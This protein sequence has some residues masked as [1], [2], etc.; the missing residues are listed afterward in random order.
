MKEYPLHFQYQSGTRTWFMGDTAWALFTDNREKRHDHTSATHHLDTRAAQ[1]FNV[2]HAMMISEAGWGNSGGPAFK[3]LQTEQINPAYWQEV[4]ARIAAAN[5]KGIT[6]G[7]V[8]A[9]G[10][11]G[12]NPN[13][14]REFPSQEARLCYARYATAR[15]SAFDVYFIVAGEWN[16][17][18]RHAAGLTEDQIRS[19]YREIGQTVRNSDPHGRLIGIHPMIMGTSREFAAEPWCGFGDYQQMYPRLHAEILSSRATGKPVVNSEYAYYLRDQ[20]ED[21]VVDKQNSYD[22]DT[23]RHATWDIAMSGGY[24]IT[25]WGNTYFGGYR[26]PGP[27]DVDAP[28]N[29]N[30]EAQVQHVKHLFENLDWWRLEPFDEGITAPVVRSQDRIAKQDSRPGNTVSPPEAVYWALAEEG[31]LYVGYVRGIS[32]SVSLSVKSGKSYRIRQFNPRTGQYRDLGA[33][34][35]DPIAF[36]PPDAQDWVFLAQAE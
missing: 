12:R 32:G 2:V 11:K 18:V 14:W 21:G 36:A 3:N 30:W 27:F 28:Q 24:F 23:I 35:G 20:D 7:L 13:D 5:Q 16:A 6:V 29:D 15:Y 34:Q 25:G 4:D 10:D 26:N 22:L 8:L 19:D 31:R 17:D 33:Q 9:W 1:G